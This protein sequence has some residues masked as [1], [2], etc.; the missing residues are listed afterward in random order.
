M[1]L[2]IDA[3]IPALVDALAR[4]RRAVLEAPP[5][6]GKTTG[7]PLALLEAPWLAGQR[8]LLLE[9]RR[10]A[11]RAAAARMAHLL[12]EPIGA[13]VGY[14]IRGESRVS[15]ATRIEVV[16]EGILTRMLQ[17]DLALDGVGLVIFD[18]FH[19]RSL[20]ADTGLALVLGG[21][22]VLREELAVL[23]MSA[24]LDGTAVSRLLGDAP[25]LRS[26]GRSFP[27][28]TSFAPPRHGS[29]LEAHLPGVIRE[30]LASTEGSVLVFLPG[31]AEIRR[32]EAALQSGALPVDVDVRPLFGALSPAAQDAAIAPPPPGR[33]KVVLATNVAETSL[34]IEGVRVV[35]DGGLERVPRFSPR[36][37]MT[38]LETRR[39]TRASADQRRGRAGRTAPGICV[40]CWSAAEDAGLV[41]SARPEIVSADLTALAL[42]LA[43]AGLADPADLPWLDPPPSGAFVEGRKLLVLLGALDVAGAVTAH[44]RA[45]AAL[46]AHPRLAH[47]LVT[48]AALG[49]ASQARAAVLAALLEER[50]LV[51]GDG[52]PPPSD[53]RLRLDALERHLDPTMLGSAAVD[54]GAV[55][56]VREAAE[57]WRRH[58]GGPRADP[59]SAEDAG[60]LLALAY[61]DRVAR[62]RGES[63]RYLLRN[64]RGA[65]L[66]PGDPLAQHEWLVVVAVDDAGRDGRIQLAAPLPSSA[67]AHLLTE[68][69]TTADETLWDETTRRVV[70]RRVTRLDAIL[71]EERALARPAA[72]ALRAVMLD[73]IRGEGV[74]ALPWSEGAARLRQR[75]AFVRAHDASWPDVG[76]DALAAHVETWLGPFLDGVDRWEAL[77]RVDL[78]AALLAQLTWEQRTALDLLAPER[79]EVPTGSRLVVDYSDASAPVL[80]VRLQ[81]VFGMAATPR[82]L[83]GAVPIVLQLLSPGYRPVQVTRDLAS[84]WRTGYFDVRK[85]L[86]GRYPKHHWPEDPLTA[87]AVRGAPRRR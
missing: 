39:I 41:P 6:A 53:L 74:T 57:R 11:A 37:G 33:R 46:G 36:T 66:P 31:A 59:P 76:D 2:P 75:L 71:V 83:G 77:S 64:G 54:H 34:T 29:R 63:G 69:A 25:L 42:D 26:E 27:V 67:V 9:P 55:V 24:T 21:S 73:V 1:S 60:T 80:A 84:F 13:R 15:H 45:M 20:V 79:L 49:P 14:R 40:R 85:D 23:V 16:T 50:D 38:R 82:V 56:R 51:R 44:G 3:L 12:G 72:E 28:S 7:V 18:E 22:R 52:A 30:A 78:A 68:G 10:L 65:S 32:V 48:A 81:E 87:T 86:R 4:E 19:E 5:G 8:I 35:V 61:P 58:L 43:V 17:D 47:L 70:A 62:R